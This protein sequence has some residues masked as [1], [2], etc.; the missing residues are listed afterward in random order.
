MVATYVTRKRNSILAPVVRKEDSA[1]HWLNYY[2]LDSW[3]N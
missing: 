2:P 1:I 3:R